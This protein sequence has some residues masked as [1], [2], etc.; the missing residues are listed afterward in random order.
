MNEEVHSRA[1]SPL[2]LVVDDATDLGET[3]GPFLESV[4]FRVAFARNGYD[5]MH[6]VVK[7]SPDIILMDLNMPGMDGT[8]TTHHLKR[9]PPTRQ[10]PILA[11]T[12]ETVLLDLERIQRRGFEDVVSKTSGP[13][14]LVR[15]IRAALAK[16]SALSGDAV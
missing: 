8:E 4:G 9:Q 13:D 14:E 3:L 1:E 15:K 16:R 2:V 12:G 11:Y 5:G 7:M 10:I 6:K